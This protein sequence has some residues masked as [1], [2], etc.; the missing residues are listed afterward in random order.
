MSAEP[1]ADRS[2]NVIESYFMIFYV[3]IVMHMF[4]G[5]QD[6]CLIFVG[7]GAMKRQNLVT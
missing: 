4:R 3:H 6:E 2:K 5:I 1:A 7:N